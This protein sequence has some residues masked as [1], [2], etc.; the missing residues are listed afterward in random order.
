MLGQGPSR[1]YTLME[2]DKIWSMNKKI[3][4]PVCPRYTCIRKEKACN[5]TIENGPSEV[6]YNV[7]PMNPIKE[8]VPELKANRPVAISKNLLID[9]DDANNIKEGEK[10]TLM[11]YGNVI[12]KSKK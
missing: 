2:W 7:A 6:F 4:D 8:S 12:I 3:I 1:K 11:K 10:I 9:F 5:L